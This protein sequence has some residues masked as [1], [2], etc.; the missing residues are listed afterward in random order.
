MNCLSCGTVAPDECTHGC[1]C[2][3]C[4]GVQLDHFKEVCRAEL[5]K[6]GHNEVVIEEVMKDFKTSGLA[7]K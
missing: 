7:R 4:L 2:A 3:H 1:E 6:E 5:K